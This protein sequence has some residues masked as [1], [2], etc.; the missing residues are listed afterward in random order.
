MLIL[1]RFVSGF[2][3]C[4]LFSCTIQNAK[5]CISK[6]WRHHLHLVFWPLHSQKQRY[7]FEILCACFLYVFGLCIFR[8]LDNLK[9]LD[10]IGNYFW[11][12]NELFN[13]GGHNWQVSKIRDGHFVERSI[14]RRLTFY[15]CVLLLKLNILAGSNIC[16]FLPKMAKHD[17]TKTLF[18]SKN[19]RQIFLIF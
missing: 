13:L 5:Y 15:D 9:I 18:F 7:C 17:V 14:L 1:C 6:M 8:F 2:Q 19:S 11:K 12:K 16:L 10:F 3:K 4:H